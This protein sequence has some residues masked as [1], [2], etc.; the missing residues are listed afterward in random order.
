MQPQ[1]RLYEART[2]L[3][4]YAPARFEAIPD[5]VARHAAAQPDKRLMLFEGRAVPW[6]EFDA[7]V[8]KVANALLGLGLQRG[9]KVAVLAPTSVE[10]LEIIVGC[11]RAGGCIVPLSTMST[12]EQL[13]GMIN[14][15]DARV[16]FLGAEMRELVEAALPRLSGLLP[17]GCIALDYSAAGMQSYEAW[18]A[19][20]PASNPG[21]GIGP[22]DHFN[23]IYSS[24]TTGI[25]KGILHDHQLRWGIIHRM[26][27]R[28]FDNSAVS[29]VSTP[30]Y[31]N[32]TAVG[33][34]PVLATGGS[35]VLMRKF[36]AGRFLELCQS[37]RVTHAM[38]VPVQYQRIMARPDFD[39]YD[40]SSF[41]AKM[42]TS[43]PLRQDIKRQV[44]AR[45]PGGMA[46]SYGLTEGG[47]N[48]S[49]DV[50][51]H[52]DKLH[53]VG[54]P[55][56]GVD[57]RIIDEQGR[58]LPQGEAGEIVGRGPSMMVGYYKQPQKT[59]DMLWRSPEG[60]TYFRSGDMG[61]FDEDGF[62]ILLDRKK[63]MIISGGFNLY[64]ADLEVVLAQH[65]GVADVAVIG[66]PSE[67]WGETPLALVVTKEGA[68]IDAEAV[69]TWANSKLGKLQRI[70]KVEFRKDL[71][72][73]TIGK[74][75]KK[76]LRAP[77]W[78]KAG[79]QI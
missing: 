8:N 67:E 68:S 19:H 39:R 43:S 37:E 35:I 9:D 77:Y 32:T 25:P 36:D 51:A 61:R 52:P 76:E 46:D 65:P 69:R 30:L 17:N 20:A 27:G 26:A 73:S 54:K 79:R 75:L 48:C 59:M 15:S 10:Y 24:G 56:P 7:R 18:L 2:P 55:V 13:E 12:A 57:M 11:L 31:S 6:G 47:G 40:L 66:V 50:M 34:Y 21:M 63:D 16:L 71:P 29:I 14:D 45:W 62:L 72:R 28:G 78:E 64:A 3:E 58:E 49:L 1:R 53:T 23:I 44:A 22:E 42:C 33:F 41:R 60:N 4:I 38:L 74:V 70:S 5:A